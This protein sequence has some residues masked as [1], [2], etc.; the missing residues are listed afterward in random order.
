[1]NDI[2]RLLP[3]SLANK[4]AAGEVVQN[5]ASVVKEL[6][7]NAVDAHATQIK[8]VIKD[9]GKALIQV[10][11]NGDGMSETDARMC[12]ERHATSKIHQTD[13][14]FK[15]ATY[16]FRGEAM[17]SIA[18][19]ARV[20]L[21][22]K[23]AIDE[24]G[25]LV[26]IEDSRLI[27]HEP[28][29]TVNGTS[30]SV[31]NLFFNVPARKK[32]MKSNVTEI[33][34]I[35]DEFYR[36]ALAYP[37]IAFSLYQE[38][39][40][41]YNLLSGKLAKRIIGLLGKQY[42]S[43][44]VPVQESVQ[45][46]RIY[47]YV[48]KPESAKKTRG[49]QFFFVNNRFIK[50]HVLH[51]A[52][53]TAFEGL[54]PQGS[55]PF[56]H[57]NIIVDYSRVDINVSPTKTEIKFDDERAI[58]SLIYAGVRSAL[59]SQNAGIDFEF[60]TN[61]TERTNHR[62]E[63]PAEENFVQVPSRLSMQEYRH[64]DEKETKRHTDN[65][66][67]WDKLFSAGVEKPWEKLASNLP[68]TSDDSLRQV[69]ELPLDQT[70]R[71][72][73]SPVL[74]SIDETKKAF[75]LHNRY[76]LY[77]VRSGAMLI[78]RV[79]AHERIIFDRFMQHNTEKTGDS[80]KVLFPKTVTLSPAD[81]IL[82]Q[83]IKEEISRIGFICDDFGKNTIIVQGI[84]ADSI[85]SNEKDIIEGLLEQAKNSKHELTHNKQETV[86]KILAKRIASGKMK[87]L[88]QEELNTLI[89]KLFASS[90][91]NYSPSGKKIIKLL[92]LEEIDD[93]LQ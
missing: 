72:V 79:A 20:E 18:S 45:D 26:I 8:L 52:V 91:P 27:T 53:M 84:P 23:R 11:D 15:I 85:E 29:A 92:K 47:G 22:S 39:S 69:P 24:T 57:L 82:F 33:K 43:A 36:V 17:A 9:A 73:L 7:E 16:G 66:R 75:I 68:D 2:I 44:L 14:L 67:N 21:K 64:L 56:Y 61:Y 6:L 78:D 1:M 34:H 83:S 90:N 71:A 12:F 65:Q 62:I 89:D 80:Q 38:D 19:V 93:M 77:Q 49:E 5:P 32:F 41:T 58:Y 3:E 31:K 55:F 50:H 76:I 46:L 28:I 40:E 48:G 86:A 59:Y 54:L 51:H 13:D 87:N 4:I 81:Y 42:Q 60:D 37:E 74:A 25:T 35:L 30:V 88:E 70:K 10:V 63:L